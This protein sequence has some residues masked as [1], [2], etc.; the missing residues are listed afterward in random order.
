M[1]GLGL[2]L[3]E[4][5][6]AQH[7]FF[8]SASPCH[9]NAPLISVRGASAENRNRQEPDQAGPP[10]I[11]SDRSESPVS[12]YRTGSSRLQALYRFRLCFLDTPRHPEKPPPFSNER[13]LLERTAITMA[14]PTLFLNSVAFPP[15]SSSSSSSPFLLAVSF[16]SVCFRNRALLN[17][18]SVASRTASAAGT[19]GGEPSI[20]RFQSLRVLEWDKLCDSVASFAGTSL[21]REAAKVSSVDRQ[22]RVFPLGDSD[23]SRAN[24]I[25]AWLREVAI[26]VRRRLVIFVEVEFWF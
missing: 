11:V 20:A 21:G 1:M 15:S 5:P 14:S 16:R 12:I 6:G 7:N 24:S 3:P 8:L 18:C 10:R 2:G 9:R 26:H 17:R 25:L 23:F 19:G 4:K 22:I 13:S